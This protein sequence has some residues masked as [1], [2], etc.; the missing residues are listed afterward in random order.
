LRRV[1]ATEYL[2]LDGVMEEPGK[3]SSPFWNDEVAKFKYDE[4]FASD[5]LLLERVTY[6]GFARAWSAMTVKGGFWRADEQPAQ[7]C[8]LDNA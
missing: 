7:V 3:W 2:T 8:R 6:E 1:V 5:A 4:S